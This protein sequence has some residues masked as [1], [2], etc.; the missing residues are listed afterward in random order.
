MSLLRRLSVVEQSAALLREGLRTGRWKGQLPGVVLLAQ[1]LGVATKTLRA[2]LLTVEAEGLVKMGANGR[3]RHVPAR[4]ARRK[5]P[6]R[7]GI[8]LFDS[9]ANESGVSMEL[10]LG[11]HH[12][13]EAAG[14]TV[15]FAEKS[16]HELGHN[17]RRI[18]SHVRKARAD[19]WVVSAAQ[20]DVL[21]WFA[22]QP[23]PTLALFGRRAGLPIAGVGPNKT[24]ALLA[25]TRQLIALGHRRIVMVCRRPRQPGPAPILSAFLAELAA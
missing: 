13:L 15:F 21:E 4:V 8:L 18:A 7:I 17:V 19:A 2:A 6:L 1:E 22:A 3:S 14:F 24:P 12:A 10:F 11:L 20:R 9:L 5:R 16:Q 25:A 23:F